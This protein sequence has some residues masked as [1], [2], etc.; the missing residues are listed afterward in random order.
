MGDSTSE[1][2]APMT[3]CLA[4]TLATYKQIVKRETR[5]QSLFVVFARHEWAEVLTAAVTTSCKLLR[6]HEELPDRLQHQREGQVA[7]QTTGG[8]RA[9]GV[10]EWWGRSSEG[11]RAVVVV[12]CGSGRDGGAVTVA[13]PPPPPAA[14]MSA[15]RKPRTPTPPPPKEE[16][17]DESEDLFAGRRVSV[18]EFDG[19]DFGYESVSSP[20]SS[21]TSSEPAYIRKPGFEHHAHEFRATPPTPITTTVGGAGGS[22]G[23]TATLITNLVGGKPI[24]ASLHTPAGL[25]SPTGSLTS[26]G[27]K[28]KKSS[29]H[30]PR[31]GRSSGNGS[32]SPNPTRPKLKKEYHYL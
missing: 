5:S 4:T 3:S 32:P 1:R 22:V 23:V 26:K 14:A 9:S 10:E 27:S 18:S 25:Q 15:K 19:Q 13:S 16:A 28:K 17:D 30:E 29:I 2:T 21:S 8:G 12:W 7:G 31:E 6:Q 20:G 24:R 11:R